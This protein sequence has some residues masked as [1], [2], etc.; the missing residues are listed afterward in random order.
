MDRRRKISLRSSML[1]RHQINKSNQ[2]IKQ[3][4]QSSVHHSCSRWEV[5]DI[6]EKSQRTKNGR[7]HFGQDKGVGERGKQ[8][9]HSEKQI[10]AKAQSDGLQVVWYCFA[11]NK[12]FCVLVKSYS[13]CSHQM[14]FTTF[15]AR[16]HWRLRAGT[17][18]V[19]IKQLVLT[20]ADGQIALSHLITPQRLQLMLDTAR[21]LPQFLSRALT[22]LNTNERQCPQKADSFP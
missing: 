8:A 14:C 16:K 10:Q 13:L 17:H 22:Q 18:Q 7:T 21:K 5:A 15:C 19:N 2:I 11:C 12:V 20:Q 1:D 9:V 6:L 3:I 4:G